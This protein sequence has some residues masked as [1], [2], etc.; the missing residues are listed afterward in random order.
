MNDMVDIPGLALQYLIELC[1]TAPSDPD[2]YAQFSVAVD[3]IHWDSSV[4]VD[5]SWQMTVVAIWGSPE[6]LATSI[7]LVFPLM[8][9]LDDETVEMEEV[10][11]PEEMT[12]PLW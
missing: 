2:L 7:E 12:T 9:L 4:A 3:R 1:P 5:G 11:E 6:E 10:V 8:Q